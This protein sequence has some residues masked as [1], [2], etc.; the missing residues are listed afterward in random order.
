MLPPPSESSEGILHSLGP[1]T[2]PPGGE[3]RLCGAPCSAK[4]C[5]NF[6][7]APAF[8]RGDP[9]NFSPVFIITT[10]ETF[11]HLFLHQNGTKLLFFSK[12]LI[13]CPTI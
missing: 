12:K 7:F 9:R 4:N 5:M 8:L 11:S 13:S 2:S 6:A 1:A 10:D 3:C